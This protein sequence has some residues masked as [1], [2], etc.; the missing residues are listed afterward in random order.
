MHENDF[1]RK[2]FVKGG[3]ALVIGFSVLGALAGKAQ[4]DQITPPAADHP[5]AGT[6]AS[7][8]SADFLPNLNS[9]D[10]WITI[11]AD[12]TATVTHGET[13]LGHGT[14]TGILMLVAEELN[15]DMTQMYYA[16]PETWLNATGGGSGSSGISSRSTQTRA[17]AAY[18][19]QVLNGLASTQ[20]GVPVANLTAAHGVISGGGSAASCSTS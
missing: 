16:H 17:A 13:E 14:P 18:G 10:S 11:N 9:V 8:T 3:G 20:L 1:S 12:N 7:R 4:A 5:S 19:M 15:M 2:T 6:F